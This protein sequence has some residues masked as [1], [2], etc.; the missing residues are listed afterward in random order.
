M[1]CL[2]IRYW[3]GK[4]IQSS[5]SFQ[6]IT[7]I[8][9]HPVI[10]TS[11]SGPLLAHMK[12]LCKLETGTPSWMHF[13]FICQRI[14][15]LSLLEQYPPL[16]SLE[17]L[18]KHT[19]R[20]CL[21][22]VPLKCVTLVRYADCT[23]VCGSLVPFTSCFC[24][25][26]KICRCAQVKIFPNFVN[27]MGCASWEKMIFVL[28]GHRKKVSLLFIRSSL[29]TIPWGRCHASSVW[30]LLKWYLLYSIVGFSVLWPSATFWKYGV[31]PAT[32]VP[33]YSKGF[34]SNRILMEYPR[35]DKFLSRC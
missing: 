21:W 18:S 32:I 5:N 19:N 34:Y 25:F 17:K 6:R 15:M 35:N 1:E 3:I 27:M 8:V 26:L 22:T 12:P 29:Y 16:L 20:Q 4:L 30:F 33:F 28:L 10:I 23:A 2:C 24:F 14:V 13:T 31:T 11:A 9:F 7:G